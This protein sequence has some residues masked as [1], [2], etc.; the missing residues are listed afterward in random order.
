LAGRIDS[1]ELVSALETVAAAAF[2]VPEQ[3]MRPYRVGIACFGPLASQPKG[4]EA[5]AT[6]RCVIKQKTV[7]AAIDKAMG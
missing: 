2:K 6:L 7:K 3:R 4:R 1:P 5:L